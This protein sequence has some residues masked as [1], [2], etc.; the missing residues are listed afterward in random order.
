MKTI[1][2]PI[3]LTRKNF[4]YQLKKERETTRIEWKRKRRTSKR[5]V[6]KWMT[7]EKDKDK[8]DEEK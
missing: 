1:K 3:G 7:K 5:R 6:K 8:R 4:I 2:I